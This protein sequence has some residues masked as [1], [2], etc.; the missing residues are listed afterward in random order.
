MINNQQ[1]KKSIF[2]YGYLSINY[3][4]SK[5]NCNEIHAIFANGPTNGYIK[6]K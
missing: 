2:P 1:N 4:K 3:M 5:N 6:H